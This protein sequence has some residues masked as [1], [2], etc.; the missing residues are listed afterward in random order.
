[1]AL[2]KRAETANPGPVAPVFDERGSNSEQR[3]KEG[4]LD[5][6]IQSNGASGAPLRGYTDV[7]ASC[8]ETVARDV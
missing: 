8:T 7:G 4:T 6:N 5:P 3:R 2:T 1:M